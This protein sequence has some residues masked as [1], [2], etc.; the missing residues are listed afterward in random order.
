M[1]LYSPLMPSSVTTL[2]NMPTM[3]RPPPP[4]PLLRSS[5]SR[6]LHVSMGSVATSAT[7]AAVPP[8]TNV[9][10]EGSSV[11]ADALRVQ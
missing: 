8:H 1:P 11:I 7:H 4:P 5:C 10:Q 2:R 3:L 6:T 9:T